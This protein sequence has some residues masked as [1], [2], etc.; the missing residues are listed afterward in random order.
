MSI[1]RPRFA[2]LPRGRHP[3]EAKHIAIDLQ[4]IPVLQHRPAD[5]LSIH[6]DSGRGSHDVEH[7]VNRLRPDASRDVAPIRVREDDGAA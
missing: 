3:L 1:Y 2:C 5:R 4:P 6:R 7:E